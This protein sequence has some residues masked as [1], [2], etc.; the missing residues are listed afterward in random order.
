MCCSDTR[1]PISYHA[2]IQD[3]SFIFETLIHRKQEK[4]NNIIILDNSHL[5]SY[6]IFY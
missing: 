3:A 6:T 1:F 2:F 4:I 5:F